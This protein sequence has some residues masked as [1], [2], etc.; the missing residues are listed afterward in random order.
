[1]TNI[2]VGNL[3]YQTRQDELEAAFGAYGTVER[4]SVVTD[5]DTGQ[6]RGFAFIEM[7]NKAEADNAIAG[8]NGADLNGRA[9]NV[10]EARPREERGGGGGGNRSGNRG[11]GGGFGR[12]RRDPRW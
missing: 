10:N 4:V 9:M 1:M 7:T 5:R 11:S 12:Q 8:L 6:P 3:S 2:F